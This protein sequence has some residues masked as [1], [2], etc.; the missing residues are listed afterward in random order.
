[1]LD[2]FHHGR[3]ERLNVSHPYDWCSIYAKTT[4]RK[5]SRRRLESPSLEGHSTNMKFS[6]ILGAVIPLLLTAC[7]PP[8][9]DPGPTPPPAPD[10]IA[11]SPPRPAS[12]VIRPGTVTQI[13]LDQLF[14]LRSE[15]KTLVVDARRSI[16]FTLG[17]ITGAINLPLPSF[18]ASFK[19]QQALLDQAVTEDKVI[20]VYCDGETCPD[21]HTTAKA[22]A[23]RGYSTSVYRGGWA[24]WKEAGME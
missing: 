7:Q 14:P 2:R 17:H 9:P 15:G 24:E 3:K 12:P 1:M 5:T 22:L 19:K 23:D 13:S 8:A 10:P 21:A 18:E 20:V 16:V 6:L 11:K 4:R